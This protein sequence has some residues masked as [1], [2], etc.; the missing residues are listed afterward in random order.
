M[1]HGKELKHGFY[2][3]FFPQFFITRKRNCPQSLN[4]H[5]LLILKCEFYGKEN[6]VEIND[7]RYQVFCRKRKSPDPEGIP[8][9]RNSFMLRLKHTN[10]VTWKQALISYPEKLN[11]TDH[12]RKACS[13]CNVGND[14]LWCKTGI[15]T[16][17]R[18]QCYWHQLNYLVFVDTKTDLISLKEP[19]MQSRTVAVTKNV[20]Q[21][22]TNLKM[23]VWLSRNM[24]AVSGRC[25][26][27]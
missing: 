16:T 4:I 22:L 14:S 5:I 27:K 10:H 11:L 24:D 9:T 17:N 21:N 23:S 12:K 25:L 20:E 26:G 13:W 8:S 19:R 15:C 18:C 7:A 2:F 3:L 1:C 6:T